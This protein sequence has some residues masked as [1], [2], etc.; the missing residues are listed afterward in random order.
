MKRIVTLLTMLSVVA[1]WFSLQ[2]LQEP[3]LT[4]TTGSANNGGNTGSSI[5][6][7]TCAQSPC[8]DDQSPV[9]NSSDASIT[10]DIPSSGYVPGNTYTITAKITKSG[11]SKF[12]FE[13]TAE[14]ISA[15]LKVGSYTLNN[16][17][18]TQKT[19]NGDAV[20][21][22][23]SGNGGPD[24]ASWSVDWTAPP[25]GTGE[26][27]FFAAFNV[28]NSNNSSSGDVIH[29]DSTTV[30]ED[31]SST[32]IPSAR[33]MQERSLNVHPIPA[34]ERI[35]ISVTDQEFKPERILLRDLQ[36]RIVQ[37]LH[38]GGLNGSEAS[39]SLD[40]GIESGTYLLEVKGEEERKLKKLLIE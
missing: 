27:T 18:T 9:Q 7:Q 35:T 6:G 10:T 24:S 22:T 23:S 26:V 4:Y 17:T 3:A 2:S 32:A 39:F 15:G 1:V 11:H 34:K 14:D 28:T 21:H 36:G 12:G 37:E 29:L 8:H 19:N 38:K 33:M 25:A 13:L 30:Q 16:A 40:A 20:T 31:T 5:D